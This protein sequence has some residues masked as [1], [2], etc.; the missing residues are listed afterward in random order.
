MWPIDISTESF[1]TLSASALTGY[2]LM[3]LDEFLN[4]LNR[5]ESIAGGSEAYR[6]MT[7]LSFEAMKITAELNNSYHEPD[8]IRAL[9]SKLIGKPVDESF[10]MFPPF[11][12]DCGKNITVG[13]NV[14]INSGCKFQDQ[15]GIVIEDGV[16]IGH[17]TVL[18]TLNHDF[19][20]DK[21]STLHPAPITIGKNVWIGSNSTILPGV[22]IGDGSII[23]AG[24]VVTKDVPAGVIVAGVPAKVIKNINL[25]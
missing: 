9:F 6:Y 21:R 24:A 10:L 11:Y 5:R 18:A 3:D 7:E 23:A 16:L 25:E 2:D 12:T 15:G 1:S 22:T 8:E 13:K 14:F 19:D 17:N 20:P 4:I